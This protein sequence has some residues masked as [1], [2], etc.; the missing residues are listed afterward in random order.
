MPVDAQIL[1]AGTAAAPLDYE[2]AN[3]TE[4]I[5]LAV[6]ATVDGSG[7]GSAFVPTVE[8]ISDGGVVVARVPTQT[9]IAAGGT[10]EVTF[11]PGL[12]GG[13]QLAPIWN[14]AVISTG[15]G[16]NTQLV[17]AVASRRIRVVQV[18]L[19][20]AGSVSVKFSDGSDLT[21]AYPLA[22]NTGFVLGPVPDDRWWFQTG[23]GNALS[24]N[25]SGGV[26]VGGII[27]YTIV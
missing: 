25:L 17:A 16:G 9:E 24:I 2:V 19:M 4:L 27:G 5:L 26:N 20:A 22:A 12:V 1:V 10:A 18:G 15:A 23:V 6:N 11:A 7:A 21:G 14:T 13:S 3:S 8:I